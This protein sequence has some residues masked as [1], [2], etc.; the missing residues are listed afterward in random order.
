M[1]S[2]LE[3]LAVATTAKLAAM[4]RARLY[5]LLNFYCEY[6]PSFSKVTEPICRLLGQDALP[7]IEAATAAIHKTVR[8]IVEG[9]RWLSA[10]LDEELRAEA[11]V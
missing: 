5:G 7:W 1:T 10:A 2:K 11:R 4:R 3:R 8:R 6:V 9:P